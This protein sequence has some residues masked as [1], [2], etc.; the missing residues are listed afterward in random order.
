MK[1]VSLLF[2]A[3]ALSIT[4]CKNV[5]KDTATIETEAVKNEVATKEITIALSP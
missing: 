2:M 3:L 5:T 1:K 4:S